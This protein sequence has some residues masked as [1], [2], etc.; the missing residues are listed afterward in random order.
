M[1][2]K[3]APQPCPDCSGAMWDNILTKKNPKQPDYVC[4]NKECGKAVWLSNTE[5]AAQQSAAA[6]AQGAQPGAPVRRPLVLDK[7][8]EKCVERAIEI[9]QKYKDGDVAGADHDIITRLAAVM[10]IARTDNKGILEAEKSALE[11]ARKKAEEEKRRA[12]ELAAQA[13]REAEERARQAQSVERS[14]A[15][16]GESSDWPPFTDDDDLPF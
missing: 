6:P 12:A 13:K 7:L 16:G 4:K 15:A 1:P 14:P 5:K 11:E 9:S 8:L 10:F 3:T 2:G